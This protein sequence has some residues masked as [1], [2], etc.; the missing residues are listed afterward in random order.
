MLNKYFYKQSPRFW[1]KIYTA[2][3]T[4]CFAFR[5]VKKPQKRPGALIPK[6]FQNILWKSSLLFFDHNFQSMVAII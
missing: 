1:K 4:A 5:M 6:D 2:R 3:A